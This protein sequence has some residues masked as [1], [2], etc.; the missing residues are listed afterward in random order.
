MFSIRLSEAK[1]NRISIYKTVLNTAFVIVWA[2]QLVHSRT[3]L[4]SE[5]F[6]PI[7]KSLK[8]LQ[9]VTRSHV[10]VFLSVSKSKTFYRV[11]TGPGKPGK[12]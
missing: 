1:E 5:M 10:P 4:I 2:L 6:D 7:L 9:V 8:A 3:S 11:R 12:S